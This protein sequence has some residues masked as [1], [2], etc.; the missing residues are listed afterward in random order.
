MSLFIRKS[1]I[2]K[3]SGRILNFTMFLAVCIVSFIVAQS[4]SDSL[5]ISGNPLVATIFT[6]VVCSYIGNFAS[7]KGIGL[8]PNVGY[9]LTITGANALI[10]AIGSV[11]LFDD[12]LS[13]RKLA[14]ILLIIIFSV[15]VVADKKRHSSDLSSGWIWFSVI[16]MLCFGMMALASRYVLDSGVNSALFLSYICGIVCILIACELRITNTRFRI[17]RSHMMVVIGAS[18]SCVIF[19]LTFF[20]AFK[21][22]PNVGYVSAVV[23]SSTAAITL[24]A[25]PLFGDHLSTRKFVGVVGV[26]LGLTVMFI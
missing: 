21:V 22:A 2:M 14:G 23:A 7:L 8:A 17:P 19:N 6:A 11:L 24:A 16:S 10:G 13:A 20:E 1:S 3:M 4:S 18:I 12:A 5:V 25:V 26:L 9:S 15:F